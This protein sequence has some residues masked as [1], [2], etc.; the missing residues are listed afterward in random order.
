MQYEDLTQKFST[1]LGVFW[2]LCV[3]KVVQRASSTQPSIENNRFKLVLFINSSIYAFSLIFMSIAV[4]LD[5]YYERYAN[6][7]LR[8]MAD[9]PPIKQAFLNGDDILQIGNIFIANYRLQAENFCSLHPTSQKSTKK[10]CQGII[11]TR[12]ILLVSILEYD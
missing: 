5:V 9:Y 3:F 10:T 7:Y 6:D 4:G 1:I 2:F 11:T 8:L 12:I